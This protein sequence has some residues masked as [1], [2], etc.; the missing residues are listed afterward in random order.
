MI[1]LK[2]YPNK[3]QRVQELHPAYFM[4]RQDFANCV[5]RQTED[6]ADCLSKVLW[7]DEER[8]TLQ[9]SANLQYCRISTTENPR[10]FVENP[11]H[12]P[13]VTAWCSFTASFVIGPVFFEEVHSSAFQTVSV[14]GDRY[15]A[16]SK[17]SVIPNLQERQTL[18]TVTFMQDET[19]PHI[20][21]V[22]VQRLL[23]SIFGENGVLLRS[24][25]HEWP[26][27]FPDLTPCDFWLWSYLKSKVY[28]NGS[29]SYA[30]LKAS[31]R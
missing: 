18:N 12:Q 17:N 30:T 28:R 9:G 25:S 23:R 26:L 2:R 11:Y 1:S 15:A 7:I 20:A 10:A 5:F 24:F 31:I 16:V 3:I 19:P 6:D 13:K 27:R 8:L 22:P 4:K 21:D 14:I 29:A